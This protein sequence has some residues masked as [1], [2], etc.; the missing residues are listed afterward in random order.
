MMYSDDNQRLNICRYI[1]YNKCDNIKYENVVNKGDFNT[2]FPRLTVDCSF[3]LL[4]KQ[5]AEASAY[6]S[7]L[8]HIIKINNLKEK[9]N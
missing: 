9:F 7:S 5:Y 1:C 6:V 3:K 4:D 2:L 8:Q